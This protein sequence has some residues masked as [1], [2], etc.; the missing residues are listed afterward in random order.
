LSG[1]SPPVPLVTGHLR[2]KH[3]LRKARGF[4]LGELKKAGLQELQARS[5]KVRIDKRRSTIHAHNV[6]SLTEFL[7]SPTQKPTVPE[8][9]VEVPAVVSEP[10]KVPELRKRRAKASTGKPAIRR[11]K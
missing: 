8:P 11:K 2:G 9:S 1:S 6:T 5:M 10:K 3:K 7:A 4:S